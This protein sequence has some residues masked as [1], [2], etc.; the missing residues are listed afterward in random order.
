MTSVTVSHAPDASVAALLETIDAS[1]RDATGHEAFPEA[2]WRALRDRPE[3]CTVA[4]GTDATV[5]A[6]SMPSDS[7]TPAFRQLA[8]GARPGTPV[9]ATREVVAGIVADDSAARLT[10]WLPGS[11]PELVAALT[12]VGFVELR[13]QHQMHVVLPRDEPVELPAGVALAPFRVGVD[14]AAWLRV[15][16]RAFA[17]HPDQGGWI[18][19]ILR[20]RIAEPWFDPA[21][22]LLAWRGDQLLG[23]CWTKVHDGSDPVG[24]IFVI[25][26]DPDAQGTG[27]GRALVLAG[28]D[29]LAR[30]RGCRTG[31]LYVAADNVAALGLY[32]ALGFTITRT[33][34]ALG[35]ERPAA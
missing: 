34:T 22:F 27:L 7:F 24:E 15:N 9:G 20:R 11:T 2:V 21:G 35:L 30:R 33:D 8:V 16:N 32:Q 28:L 4:I 23:F 1:V 6:V 14:D 19:E 13:R 5:A 17:N 31:L 12:A 18:E 29:D 25:G 3:A 10:A 26:V